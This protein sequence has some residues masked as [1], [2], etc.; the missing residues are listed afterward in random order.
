MNNKRK[1]RDLV[2][3]VIAI[4]FCWLY[5]PHFVFMLSEHKR[6]LVMED[7]SVMGTR[8]CIQINN[9]MK[10]LFLLHNNAYFRKLFYHRIGPFGSIFIKW[11]RPGNKYFT[12][13]WSTIID[14]GVFIAHPYSTIINASIIGKN[15][16]CRHL[17]TIGNKSDSDGSRPSIGDNV[18]LGAN[19]TIIGGI[20]IGNNVT[21]GA[22][23]VVVKD[24]PDNCVVAGNPAK[25]IK[26]VL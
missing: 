25:I 24:I 17:T 8:I 5:I 20:H 15:F 14:G 6:R 26:Y 7:V 18:C 23:S 4:F 12:L 19:V 16:S 10:L 2:S 1:Y 21:I 9:W 22:G 3:L 13:S 11:Y